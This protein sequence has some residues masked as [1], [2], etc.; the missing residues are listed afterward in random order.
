MDELLMSTPGADVVLLL[1][2]HEPQKVA[3]KLK[4]LHGQDVLAIAELFGGSGQ[5]QSAGFD[6]TNKDLEKAIPEIVGK[7]QDLR[8]VQLGRA[9]RPTFEK[10]EEKEIPK[11]EETP[12]TEAHN[13]FETPKT[14]EKKEEAAPVAEK[15]EEKAHEVKDLFNKFIGAEGDEAAKSEPKA[16]PLV[17]PIVQAL[18]SLEHENPEES[19]A[20]TAKETPNIDVEGAKTPDN[21][22]KA[23]GDILKEHNP[24][25]KQETV[26]PEPKPGEDDIRTL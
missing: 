18:E 24:I 8:D 1:A 16:I 17:D 10:P 6:L 25:E 21:P 12:K 20:E 5:V 11:Q 23:L 13:H 4:G 15:P 19:V 9:P 2:E 26:G 3:G 22:F 14:E 7:V